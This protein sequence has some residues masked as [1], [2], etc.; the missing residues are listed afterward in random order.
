MI[1]KLINQKNITWAIGGSVLLY[2]KG[3]VDDFNDIDIMVLEDDVDKLQEILVSHGE[4][5]DHTSNPNYQTRH[6][7]KININGV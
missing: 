3:F 7:Y 5:I 1:A 2:L 6:F 4:L